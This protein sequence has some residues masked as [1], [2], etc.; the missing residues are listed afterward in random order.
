MKLKNFL[1]I[2]INRSEFKKITRK[3]NFSFSKILL[4]ALA[5][6]WTSERQTVKIELNWTSSVREDQAEFFLW[7]PLTGPPDA[8]FLAVQ[9]C[10][11]LESRLTATQDTKSNP[12]RSEIPHKKNFLLLSKVEV[13]FVVTKVCDNLKLVNLPVVR[14]LQGFRSLE[15]F[16]IFR[17]SE[18]VR[19]GRQAWRE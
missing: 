17:R 14:L 1:E 8:E 3:V 10:N 18:R 11:Y 13:Q 2:A 16:R 12:L 5:N 4:L 15:F 9:K 7:D 6:Y 19:R